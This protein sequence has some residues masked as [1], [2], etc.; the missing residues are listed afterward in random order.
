MSPYELPCGPPG[1]VPDC[2]QAVELLRP[3]Y[4]RTEP[5]RWLPPESLP[6]S[7]GV[8]LKLGSPLSRVSPA[9][10][11]SFVDR[12]KRV[13]P[14]VPVAGQVPREELRPNL[15]AVPNEARFSRFVRKIFDGPFD[16]AAYRAA[17]TEYSPTELE[18]WLHLIGRPA[19]AG[20]I[21]VIRCV[22]ELFSSPLAGAISLPASLTRI[23]HGLG[24]PGCKRWKMLAKTLPAVSAM[25][26]GG[27]TVAEAGRLADY[28]EESAF[29]R[30]CR[31]LFR[32]PPS[33][34]RAHAG[35]EPLLARFIAVWN[36]SGQRSRLSEGP[37]LSVGESMTGSYAQMRDGPD[38]GAFASG[39]KTPWRS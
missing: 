1:P 2:L 19:T 33:T 30:H 8:L 11:S 22:V 16:Q 26:K 23:L 36:M 13:Y 5:W 24:F 14:G 29:R 20:E 38:S 21:G 31:V 9:P 15:P 10:L 35:W 37:A 18:D 39:E 6:T 3:P 34:L 7:V 12:F 27:L 28:V 25:Q 17:V 4:Q 32:L